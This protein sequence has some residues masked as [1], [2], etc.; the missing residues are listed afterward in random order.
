MQ[1][2]KPYLEN[3]TQQVR[4]DFTLREIGKIHKGVPLCT[5]ISP[6]V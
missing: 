5:V 2:L 4:I 1:F 3:S 6:I